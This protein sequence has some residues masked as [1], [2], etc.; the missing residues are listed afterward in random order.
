MPSDPETGQEHIQAATPA[1]PCPNGAM[2]LPP[3]LASVSRPL[4][5]ALRGMVKRKSVEREVIDTGRPGEANTPQRS[6]KAL[7]PKG[8][9]P[10]KMAETDDNNSRATSSQKSDPKDLDLGSRPDSIDREIESARK[11]LFRA[12][13]GTED[14]DDDAITVAMAKSKKWKPI[15]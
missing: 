12:S 15:K 2:P 14:G 10:M 9:S 3:P 8:T 11:D 13:T 1:G 6:D 4:I 7:R 5:S